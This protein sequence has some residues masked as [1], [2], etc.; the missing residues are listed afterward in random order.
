MYRHKVIVRVSADCWEMQGAYL[1]Q[2][3]YVFVHS[4]HWVTAATSV[5]FYVRI[6]VAILI[7]VYVMYM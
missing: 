6:M 1:S 3:N 7:Y 4:E 5:T 2:V